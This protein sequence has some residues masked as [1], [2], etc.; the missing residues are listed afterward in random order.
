MMRMTLN[1]NNN[2]EMESADELFRST[3]EF[4]LQIPPL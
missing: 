1:M 2:E 3:D 4:L